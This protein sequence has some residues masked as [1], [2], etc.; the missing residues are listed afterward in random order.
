MV[1]KTGAE[2]ETNKVGSLDILKIT[3]GITTKK[4]KI[5]VITGARK[6]VQIIILK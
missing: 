4:L 6:S 2:S 3:I 5:R 1:L